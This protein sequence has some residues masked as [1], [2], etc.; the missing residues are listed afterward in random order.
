MLDAHT[1]EVIDR[2]E[3]IAHAQIGTGPGGNENGHVRI[4]YRLPLP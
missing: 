4:R 1:G 2:W 3:G